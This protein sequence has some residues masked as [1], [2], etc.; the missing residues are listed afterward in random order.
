[1]YET[2]MVSGK[3]VVNID[4]LTS[5]LTGNSEPLVNERRLGI[6]RGVETGTQLVLTPTRT[7]SCVPVSTPFRL[8]RSCGPRRG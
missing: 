3:T 1:M 4:G 5:L 8:P 6:T 7:T 2:R